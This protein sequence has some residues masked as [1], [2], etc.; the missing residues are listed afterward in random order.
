MKRNFLLLGR[1]SSVSDVILISALVNH[2]RES[3]WA[4]LTAVE[5]VPTVVHEGIEPILKAFTIF[6]AERLALIE[7]FNP[8][9]LCGAF[10]S[11][12]VHTINDHDSK[13]VI[14]DPGVPSK[15]EFADS[16]LHRLDGYRFF[17]V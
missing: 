9:W 5:V 16:I 6:V 7:S 1:H 3:L 11:V 14:T 15:F 13:V 12:C 10:E 4:L 17:V 8:N 2:G